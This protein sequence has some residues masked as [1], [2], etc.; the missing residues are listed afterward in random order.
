MSLWNRLRRRLQR[1]RSSKRAVGRAEAET[2]HP[3]RGRGGGNLDRIISDGDADQREFISSQTGTL[4][5]GLHHSID[6]HMQAGA[7]NSDLK[8]V[9]A[10]VFPV[11]T[12]PSSPE[13]KG[14]SDLAENISQSTVEKIHLLL[15]RW[16]FSKAISALCTWD[17]FCKETSARIVLFVIS[18]AMYCAHR[19]NQR[20]LI[21][22]VSGVEL[23]EALGLWKVGELPFGQIVAMVSSPLKIPQTQPLSAEL[24][25]DNS[26][27]ATIPF[28]IEPPPRVKIRVEASSRE[29]G[30]DLM[31]EVQSAPSTP[32][33]GA[34]LSVSVEEDLTKRREGRH[35]RFSYKSFKPFRSHKGATPTMDGPSSAPVSPITK[36]LPV[37]RFK[38]ISERSRLSDF[39]STPLQETGPSSSG[40]SPLRRNQKHT[41]QPSLHSYNQVRHASTST[42]P[43][44]ISRSSILKTTEI[45]LPIRQSHKLV[46]KDRLIKTSH[47]KYTITAFGFVLLVVLSSL[48]MGRFTSILCT[49]CSLLLMSNL[50]LAMAEEESL[51]SGF[52][53]DQKDNFQKGNKIVIP[54]KF[55]D[56]SSSEYKKRVI[57]EG[58]LERNHNVP[59]W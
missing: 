47:G 32:L 18:F 46:S 50:R 19:L 26:T 24:Q 12:S 14:E 31:T 17:R 56:I 8:A 52:L 30:D 22:N 11:S 29:R 45:K 6:P 38:P 33:L 35:F 13:L 23:N 25:L 21:S 15:N 2:S 43:S 5:S 51:K 55:N 4:A 44:S 58:L 36:H 59:I 27:T 48:T 16:A 57:M 3:Y 1:S 42:K 41:K 7:S 9:E 28:N 37:S 49:S 40:S 34:R 39:S 10:E 53:N 20:W 54:N